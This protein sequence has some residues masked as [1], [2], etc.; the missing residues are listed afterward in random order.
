M[1]VIDIEY[2][3][4]NTSS[5][6][7][8]VTIGIEL[9]T[10]KDNIQWQLGDLGKHFVPNPKQGVTTSKTLASFACDIGMNARTL[11]EY[12]KVASFYPEAMRNDY[13]NLS[14]SHWRTALRFADKALDIAISF[15][16]YASDEGLS[17]DAFEAWL[18]ESRDSHVKRLER[19]LDKTKALLQEIV[20]QV[21]LSEELLK[22]INEVL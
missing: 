18:V 20:A 12:T 21:T 22:R 3:V 9:R 2:D 16:D 15:L 8:L 17:C 5:Y 13:P 7:E 10:L 19:Q 14:Y 4:T 1:T 6:E 11:Q